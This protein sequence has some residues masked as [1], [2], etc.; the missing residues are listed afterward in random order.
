MQLKHHHVSAT[1]KECVEYTRC[2]RNMPFSQYVVYA[3]ERTMH[4]NDLFQ[5]YNS[6]VLAYLPYFEKIMS[7]V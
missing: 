1:T 6:V 2:F 3:S 5:A 4:F 7:G